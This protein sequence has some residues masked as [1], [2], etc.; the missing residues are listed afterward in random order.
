MKQSLIAI[1]IGPVQDFI[2]SARR[3]RDLWFGSHMLSEIAKD[4]A[5]A[6]KEAGGKLIFPNPAAS[7]D[8]APDSDFT[9]ANVI[10]AETG[11]PEEAA[12]RAEA[13]AQG[14]W[15]EF[16][17][18]ARKKAGNMIRDDVWD[19][20]LSDVVEFY[21]AW[22]TVE[23]GGYKDA[24]SRVM[25]LLA[26]RKNCRDFAPFLGQAGLPKSSLDGLRETV[27][28]ENARSTG[29]LRIKPGE[30]LCAVGVTKRAAGKGY[31]PSVSRVAV[32]P[33]IRGLKAESGAWNEIEAIKEQCDELVRLGALSRVR[34]DGGLFEEFPYEGTALYLDRLVS[35]GKE[36]PVGSDV[37]DILEKIRGSLLTLQKKKFGA[38][39]PYFVV[40]CA[41]GDKMGK[42]ISEAESPDEHRAISL[43][44]SEFASSARTIVRNHRGVCVY[45]GG[46]DVLAFLPCDTALPC[47][48]ELHDDFGKMLQ[49]ACPKQGVS[50][51]PTLS[52]G[53]AIGHALEDLADLLEW[54]RDAERRAKA[55]GRK[56]VER[57]GLAVVVRSRGG[58]AQFVRERWSVAG[59]ENGSR[60]IDERLRFWADAYANGELPFKFGYE[61]RLTAAFYANWTDE[62]ACTSALRKDLARIFERKEI[63]IPNK[64]AVLEEIVQ[65]VSSAK[66]LERLADELII[67]QWISE[68]IGKA[69]GG[70]TSASDDHTA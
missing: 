25:R 42:A 65:R 1:S 64:D 14:R 5:R 10:L 70:S 27:L 37:N 19:T 54:G 6:V 24:R 46:D 66:D 61:L 23:N 34:V 18:E 51:S 11:D 45:T 20:Q 15:L 50:D 36:A 40:L 55:D 29:A 57:D 26:A 2:K 44:L 4:A 63:S 9:V 38:P 39:S 67:G 59:A 17:E 43:A 22:T 3:T 7:G 69:K 48:R 47:A 8:L 35:I 62:N 30:S 58:S 13:A 60:P 12:K 53:I 31:F 32:D 16:A 28:K 52:V 49:N 56:D 21:A 33:W 41:D 68:S